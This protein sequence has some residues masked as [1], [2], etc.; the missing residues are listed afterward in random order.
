MSSGDKEQK[1][2][3]PHSV[4]Q[5]GC[6]SVCFQMVDGEKRLVCGPGQRL[7]HCRA[8]DQASYQ[9]GTRRSG[10]PVYVMERNACLGEC[11]RNE[12]IEMVE[13]G[14]R[15]NL[16]YD[17]AIRQVLRELRLDQIG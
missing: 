1:I 2:W 5:A 16:G 3:E 17:T 7:C 9:T 12:W 6:Q 4:G 14:A 13:M 11:T 8:D 10:Y 15:C